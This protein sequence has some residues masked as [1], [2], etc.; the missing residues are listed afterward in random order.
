MVKFI[1]L[2]KSSH[3]SFLTKS[4]HQFL[5]KFLVNFYS[6][7]SVILCTCLTLFLNFLKKKNR[8]CFVFKL[9]FL[10]NGKVYS[11]NRVFTLVIFNK[12]LVNFQSIFILFFCSCL[13]FEQ[14]FSEFFCQFLANFQS[15]FVQYFNF[16]FLIFFFLN[17][18]FF[19]LRY[20][21]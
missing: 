16:F 18:A 11:F 8:A 5:K 7:F 15:N 13:F 21:F 20:C 14:I 9:L 10:K 4:S 3:Y 6:I 17:C 19:F 1:H 2:T 12:V